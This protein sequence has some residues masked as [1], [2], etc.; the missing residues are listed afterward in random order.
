MKELA[1]SAVATLEAV[2]QAREL[3]IDLT[4]EEDVPLICDAQFVRRS[5][6]NLLS[7]AIKYSQSGGTIE[8]AV[9]NQGST[10]MLS[11]A[12]CGDGIPN[13]MKYTLFEKFGS[14]E[15]RGGNQRRGVGLGLYLVRLVAEA[16]GGGVSV[17]DGPVRGTV[18]T[19][20][21]PRLGPAERDFKAPGRSANT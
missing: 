6:E 10:I 9:R 1:A 12:D 20:S 4:C 18:F 15:A 11:V 7:N 21:F 14:V 13:P 8:V 16:H 3:Q 2:A 17:H 19:L 5:I